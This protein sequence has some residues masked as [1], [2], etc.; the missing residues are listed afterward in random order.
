MFSYFW[1]AV[2]L[3]A[4]C[5]RATELPVRVVGS[6]KGNAFENLAIRYNQQILAT[7]AFPSADVYL[8]DPSKQDLAEP[9]LLAMLPGSSG[10]YGISELGNTTQRDIFFLPSAKL[11]SKGIR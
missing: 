6:V 4:Q 1:S 10:S 5:L 3:L 11:D 7:T 8:F 9:L 2:F